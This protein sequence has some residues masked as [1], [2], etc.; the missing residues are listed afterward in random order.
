MDS[1]SERILALQRDIEELKRAV[2][3]LERRLDAAEQT[4]RERRST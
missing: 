1:D 4:L 3:D 2:L